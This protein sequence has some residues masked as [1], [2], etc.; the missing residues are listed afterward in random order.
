MTDDLN[1]YFKYAEDVTSGRQIACQ[2]VKDVCSRYLS[3][4]HR[5]D[6]CFYPQ[7][8]QKVIDFVEKLEHFQGKWAGKNFVLS[9]WQKFIIYYVYGFYYADD[10]SERV[11]KHV[12]LDCARK[13][14]K[15]MFVAALS[16]YALI[17]EKES[18]A[19]IDIVANSRQQAHILFDMCK[20]VS[21]RMDKRGR[22]LHSTLNRVKFEKTDSFIQVLAS[23]AASLDGY[24]ASMFVED[25][26]HAAKDTQLFDVLSSSQ[27]ARKNP[28]S[29]IVTTAGKNPLSPYYQMRKSAIDVIQGR[30]DNDSLVAFIYTLDDSDKW[31]DE[32][33][34][35]KSNPNLNVTVSIDY[36]RDR[37]I[38]A[39]TSSLIENDVKVKTLNCW[40][41]SIE[42]WISDSNITASMQSVD[43][44]QF[45]DAECFVGVD[46][47]AVSDLTCWSVLFPPDAA[48][49]IWPD[50]YIFKSFA[51]LPEETIGKSENGYLYR[52]FLEHNELISTDG[53]VTD[54]DI[55]LKD[56][57]CL[58]DD[59]YILSVAYD[60]WNATQFAINAT[61]A[62]LIMQP[63]SMSIGNMN[64][65]V[66]ELERLILSDKVII[67]V[68]EL[69][70]WCF[71]NVRIKTDNH[72]NATVDKA[73]KAQKIDAVVSMVEALG[74]YLSRVQGFDVSQL[75]SD[76]VAQ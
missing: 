56:L 76:V 43:L 42:T 14:G 38:Q 6:I 23:D 25:E 73:Q 45:K 51:Y 59:N 12:I 3:W 24:S 67:D 13:Q 9:E 26:M 64:R 2:Y 74:A 48:R 20:N 5:T 62:G 71:S 46:L 54:Y 4:M 37:I 29:W 61:N 66:K 15:S 55:I 40:V 11:I 65:P 63:F 50:K 60:R 70:R 32:T 34:W 1:K 31:T 39:K 47:A 10:D 57:L 27:G 75:I 33:V 68:S 8:A 19:E 28:L 69:V 36:I 7:R 35:Q 53:N 41:Q 58:N 52:R 18:A 72:D 21:K 44:Q 16:L 30:I 49:Q 22:H 17:G